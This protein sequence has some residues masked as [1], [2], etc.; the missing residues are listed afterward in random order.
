[1]SKVLKSK[2]SRKLIF[3]EL[4]AN[5]QTFGYGKVRIKPDIFSK[6]VVFGKWPVEAV[7]IFGRIRMMSTGGGSCHPNQGGVLYRK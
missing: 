7:S 2:Y 1:M 4:S 5:Q 6:K 3:A